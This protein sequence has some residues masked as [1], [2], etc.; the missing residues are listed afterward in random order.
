[1][2]GDILMPRLS[3]SM[4]EGKLLQ[5]SIAPGASVKKGDIIAEVEADKANMEI[6]SPESGTL[7]YGQFVPGDTVAVGAVVATIKN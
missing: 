1:M 6:E 7:E 5:W 3:E 2:V 4:T